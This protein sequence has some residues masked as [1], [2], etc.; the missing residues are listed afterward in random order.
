MTTQYHFRVT[1]ESIEVQPG[2]HDSPNVTMT[3]KESDYLDMVNGKLN[4]QMAFMSGTLKITGDMGL[5]LKLQNLFTQA[6][7]HSPPA[8]TVQQVIDGMLEAF[9]ADAAKGID[10]VFQFNLTGGGT[11]RSSKE[12]ER[13]EESGQSAR[14]EYEMAGVPS[15]TPVTELPFIEDDYDLVPLLRSTSNELLDPLVGYLTDDGEG[16]ISSEL[17]STGAYIAHHPDHL[18]YVD[19]IAAEIQLFGGNTIANQIRGYGVQY[20]EICRDV[21]KR[22][23][24][25]FNE[26]APVENVESQILMK[27]LEDAWDK[28]D[29]EEKR[30]F[31]KELGINN[32]ILPTALPLIAVQ[33]AMNASGF[34]AYRIAVIVANAV[35]QIVLGRGLTFATNRAL[36]KGLGIFA[37]PIGWAVTALW[38]T[39]DLASPAY[40]VT[41]PSV[42]QI[43]LIRQ[44]NMTTQCS[45]GHTNSHAAKFCPGCGEKLL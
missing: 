38:T 44:D 29:E 4:G 2:I 17:D 5:A 45:N 34:L 27:V 13:L 35:A 3:M 39:I 14:K 41:I 12:S 1:N 19:E 40:R 9:N 15:L 8:E 6:E 21:A 36:T 25:N 42:I 31:L 23:K 18:K 37:G 11:I 33:A 26:T 10:A 20:A 32:K 22:L 43:A 28:M 7:A 24:V 16:R 30:A